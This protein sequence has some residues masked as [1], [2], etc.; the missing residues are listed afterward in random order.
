MSNLESSSINKVR[1][2]EKNRIRNIISEN[3]TSISRSEN[4]IKTIRNG[5]IKTSDS[6]FFS[7]SLESHRENIKTKTEENEKLKKH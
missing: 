6:S 3:K 4:S 5:D 2:S 7:K 1:I